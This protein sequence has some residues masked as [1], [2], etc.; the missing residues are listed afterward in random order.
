MKKGGLPLFS[1]THNTETMEEVDL[2]PPDLET[3]DPIDDWVCTPDI[4]WAWDR[5]LVRKSTNGEPW[6]H[7]QRVLLQ[8]PV[9]F[10]CNLSV[11]EKGEMKDHEQR[12]HAAE[13]MRTTAGP[14]TILFFRETCKFTIPQGLDAGELGK[15][16]LKGEEVYAAHLSTCRLLHVSPI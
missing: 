4:K 2:L 1:P 10:Y 16:S 6:T 7:Q 3:C 14:G 12:A 13:C 8:N 5:F 15:T 11:R 9:I